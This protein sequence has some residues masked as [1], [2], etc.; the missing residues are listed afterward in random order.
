MW[1]MIWWLAIAI[2][3]TRVATVTPQEPDI[4]IGQDWD[5]LVW[6]NDDQLEWQ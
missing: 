3:Q 1:L 5:F 4:L 2:W 6:Q